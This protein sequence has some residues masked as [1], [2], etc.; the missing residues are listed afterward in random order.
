MLAID[1]GELG[2]LLK[3][4]TDGAVPFSQGGDNGRKVVDMAQV[5]EFI[6]K[7]KNWLAAIAQTELKTSGI[8]HVQKN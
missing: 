6:E 1:N 3:D 5:S 7:E 2:Q 4:N 8:K